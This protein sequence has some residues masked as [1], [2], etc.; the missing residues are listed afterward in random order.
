MKRTIGIIL[1]A[2]MAL[3]LAACGGQDEQASDNAPTQEPAQSAVADGTLLAEPTAAL[4]MTFQTASYK[5]L[6]IYLPEKWSGTE[7]DGA[8]MAISDDYYNDLGSVM[9]WREHSSVPNLALDGSMDE[10]QLQ[11]AVAVLM[12]GEDFT[13]TDI[14]Y[15]S[16]IANVPAV[17]IVGEAQA[18]SV[19]MYVLI[20]ITASPT[21]TNFVIL[22]TSLDYTDLELFDSLF[23]FTQIG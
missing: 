21:I 1:A 2:L 19:T 4:N 10:A 17:R 12:G 7:Y 9:A 15:N 6:T 14:N 20:Y 11:A 8:F 5:N 3:T 13:A 16:S 22:G 18:D 23:G